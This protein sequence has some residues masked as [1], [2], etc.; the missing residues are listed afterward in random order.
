MST[1]LAQITEQAIV[2]TPSE[3]AQLAEA[4]LES[5]QTTHIA[6]IESAWEIEIQKRVSAFKQ[7][8]S[9]LFSAEDVFAEVE[10][11]WG[12]EADRREV[13]ITSGLIAAVSGQEAVARLRARLR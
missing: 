2:L 6:D 8:V 7:G 3:R 1:A 10:E 9:E 11:A 13:G 12:L 5:L 4:L